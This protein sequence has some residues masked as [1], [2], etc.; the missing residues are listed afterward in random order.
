MWCVFLFNYLIMENIMDA[1]GYQSKKGRLLACGVLLTAVTLVILYVVME[2]WRM[3]LQVPF[4]YFNDALL[5]HQMA[6]SMIDNGWFL[7]NAFL[8][9]PGIMNMY[10]F[11][12]PENL[13]HL[14]IKLISL[15]T[16]DYA[17]SMNLFLIVT[18]PL[19]TVITWYVLM[20]LGLSNLASFAGGLLY[21]FIP[22]HYLKGQVHITFAAYY[23]IP[24]AM[25]LVMRIYAGDLDFFPGN[26][27][28]S[29]VDERKTRLSSIII[30]ALVSCT[31]IYYSFFSCFFLIVA[32]AGRSS[33]AR[34]ITP[35][36]TSLLL[37]SIIF[38][39]LIVNLSSSLLYMMRNGPNLDATHRAFHDADLYS[40]RV[41]KLLL[42][43]RGHRVKLL[44]DVREQYNRESSC[45]S[46]FTEGESDCAS[47]GVLCGTGFIISLA[48]LLLFIGW[49]RHDVP[50][51][52]RLRQQGALIACA[53]LLATS[54]GFS[55]FVAP[56]VQFRI[57][58]YS[59]ISIFIAFFSLYALM[60]VI[61]LL[62]GRYLK[63]RWKPSFRAGGRMIQMNL[64]S[65]FAAAIMALLVTFGICDQVGRQAIPDYSSIGK[66]YA[67]DA[68]FVS[69]VEQALPRDA[70]IF[71]LPYLQFP[72][73]TTPPHRLKNFE[74]F[75]YYLHS[76]TVRW[77]YGATNG[78]ESAAW[79]KRVS[80]LPAGELVREVRRSGFKAICISTDGYED[81][82]AGIIFRLRRFARSP[83]V[84]S[85]DARA[86]LIPL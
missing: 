9:A 20:R 47:L 62:Y 12:Q 60:I 85:D 67:G 31:G 7:E 65:L 42:P 26:D 14:M 4:D 5:F 3:D 33:M 22:Y 79:Q 29:S 81:G 50:S 17:A 76:K 51:A 27:A 56:L 48:S 25:M 77:S 53:V 44:A 6:K 35:L 8:G 83:L 59:R 73:I 82:G 41:T 23:M 37:S 74:Y 70:M 69:M 45:I 28:K 68:R 30:A 10:D 11:P 66:R 72:E 78:R 34:K 55:S 32:G 57:R 75:K 84:V 13:H 61:D 43:V 49:G 24:L 52:A 86:V 80:Q 1:T 54:A 2:L 19:T 40:L 64:S 36:A 46:R 38:T 18:Y 71:Q 58:S 39:G 63:D 16:G 21:A 15:V